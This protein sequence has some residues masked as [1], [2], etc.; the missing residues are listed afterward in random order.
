MKSKFIGYLSPRDEEFAQLWADCFFVFDANAL[1]N[2]YEYSPETRNELLEVLSAPELKERIWIP[3]QVGVEFFRDRLSVINKQKK[4]YDMATG[5][6]ADLLTR[7]KSEKSHPFLQEEQLN[8]FGDMANEVI[9]EL[10]KPQ[11]PDVVP[12]HT[13]PCCEGFSRFLTTK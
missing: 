6:V 9:K 11:R 8:R 12:D 7:L 5:D 4:T 13:T 10:E 3:H 1:L 2:L